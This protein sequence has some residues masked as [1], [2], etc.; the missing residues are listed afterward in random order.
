[1]E[2]IS[3]RDCANFEER[4]D[5]DNVVLCKKNRRPHVC[6][7]DF[8]PMDESFNNR[9]YYRFCVDCTYFEDVNETPLCAK[10]HIP[11]VACEEFTD[12]Y[13][14]AR[15]LQIVSLAEATLNQAP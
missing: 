7:E 2:V 4:R 13:E 9:L 5:I 11:G 12:R 8:K 1:M 6:C 15:A 3:C 14:K 10:N